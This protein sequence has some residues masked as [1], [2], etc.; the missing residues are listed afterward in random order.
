MRFGAIACCREG[1]GNYRRINEG[2]TTGGEV[3]T[4]NRRTI[5]RSGEVPQIR[6]RT[7]PLG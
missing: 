7:Q 5:G 2:Y 4:T 6:Y 1:S 3:E